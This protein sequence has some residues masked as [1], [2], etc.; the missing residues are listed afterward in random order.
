MK[1]AKIKVFIMPITEIIAITVINVRNIE[2]KIKI[3]V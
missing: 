3:F 2:M 1:A